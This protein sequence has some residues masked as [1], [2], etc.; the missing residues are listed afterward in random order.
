[1]DNF[2]FKLN[3]TINKAVYLRLP[4]LCISVYVYVWYFACHNVLSMNSAEVDFVFH[5]SLCL[6][7]CV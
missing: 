7:L 3:L 6:T 1:M 4:C 2:R 5:P